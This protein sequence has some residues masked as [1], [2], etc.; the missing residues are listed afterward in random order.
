MKSNLHTIPHD[1]NHDPVPGKHAVIKII[2]FLVFGAAVASG[3]SAML[4]MAVLLVIMLYLP[5]MGNAHPHLKTALMM[6]KRLRWLFLSILVLYLF[7]TPGRLL[8]PDVLWGP[9][10]E[11]LEQGGTRIGAL[12]LIVAAVNWLL[13]ST[14]QDDFLSAVIWCLRPLVWLGLPHERLAVRI[15]LTL[16]AVSLVRGHYRHQP[17]QG[18]EEVPAEEVAR[19]SARQQL[20]TIAKTAHRLFAEVVTVAESAPLRQ[21]TL[22]AQSR[23]PLW[24]WLI[25]LLL[26]ALFVAARFINPVVWY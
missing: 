17:R 12:V 15:A 16:E 5:G 25:P 22:P 11:G 9:T 7:F 20:L 1:C 2:S 19:P 23:P 24:Q 13:A 4:L 14:A 6:L 18:A 10:L 21:I 26:I 3:S 8:W